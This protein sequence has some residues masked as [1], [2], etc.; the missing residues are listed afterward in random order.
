MKIR[1]PSCGF[2]NEK[3]DKFCKNCEESLPTY[4]R[5]W[6]INRE[7]EIKHL[8]I[9]KVIPEILFASIIHG[10][11][12]FAKDDPKRKK[13]PELQKVGL[14]ICENFGNDATLFEVGCYLYFRLD[15]WLFLNRP[16]L[17][18]LI[19]K[20]FAKEFVKLFTF[21]LNTDNAVGLFNER[22]SMYGN[23]A[24]KEEGWIKK[25]H[26]I[27]SRLVAQTKDNN[28]P[29][30]YQIDEIPVNINSIEDLLIKTELISWEKKIVP[31]LLNNN[32]KKY[33]DL[34]EE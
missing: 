4:V 28:L 31:I 7:E 1:C 19:S 8:R 2:E 29:E 20:N 22:I 5:R 12:F 14:D 21:A 9:R 6:D 33:C 16:D 30:N 25:A 23:L 24:T 27:L 17:R 26:S 34:L 11:C 15:L 18:N 10:L 13:I 32:L 3:D